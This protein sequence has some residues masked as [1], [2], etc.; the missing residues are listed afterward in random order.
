MTT[1]RMIGTEVNLSCSICNRLFKEPRIARCGHS[2][3]RVCLEGV[4]QDMPT[5]E[6]DPSL[7]QSGASPSI[8]EF[9]CPF[10]GCGRKSRL[11]SA[12]IEEFPPNC[13]LAE[14]V[15]QNSSN[16]GELI[17]KCGEHQMECQMFCVHCKKEICL[18]CLTDHRD[19]PHSIFNKEEAVQTYQNRAKQHIHQASVDLESLNVKVSKVMSI[20]E[21]EGKIIKE[22][23]K[24]ETMFNVFDEAIV[25]IEDVKVRLSMN[26]L[27]IT[28]GSQEKRNLGKEARENLNIRNAIGSLKR[29]VQKPT[30]NVFSAIQCEQMALQLKNKANRLLQE[31]RI[32]ENREYALHMT[33]DP[34]ELMAAD[35]QGIIS[36][37]NSLLV[38][39]EI[40]LQSTSGIKINFLCYHYL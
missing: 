9:T 5:T 17:S 4:L 26:F 32:L 23:S 13:S 10:P 16:E 40:I 1:I 19:A 25:L 22:F 20:H 11:R 28:E 14:I 3:C 2:F 34:E 39:H 18:K 38:K 31:S 7:A 6:E 8:F 36:K 27:C 29:A 30:A 35:I 24:L 15:K 21:D 12:D 37:I 33:A